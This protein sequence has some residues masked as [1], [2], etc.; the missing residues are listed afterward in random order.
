M[1]LVSTPHEWPQPAEMETK[2]T[3]DGTVL[4]PSM[5]QPQQW[6]V[7]LV[8]TPHEWLSPVEMETKTTP[9]GTVVCP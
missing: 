9:D 7:P 4:R 5:F 6:P 1:P 3:P 2:T 8:S